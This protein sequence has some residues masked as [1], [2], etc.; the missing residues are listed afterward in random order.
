MRLLKQGTI[1]LDGTKVRGMVGLL[2]HRQTKGSATDSVLPTTP[3]RLSTPLLRGLIRQRPTPR[4]PRAAL[5]IRRD[6]S[7]HGPRREPGNCAISCEAAA[8]CKSA[9]LIT[10][11]KAALSLI[12]QRK[13]PQGRCCGGID[14]FRRDLPRLHIV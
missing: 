5:L 10:M 13:H 12:M 1:A 4:L 6:C 8:Q 9:G 2:G 11:A 14:D 7:G 3:R